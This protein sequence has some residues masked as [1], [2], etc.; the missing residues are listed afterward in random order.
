MERTGGFS[1]H[2]NG[3]VSS[4]V[5]LDQYGRPFPRGT[6][7][8]GSAR[9]GGI[10]LPHAFTL[11]ARYEGADHTYLHAR[12]DEALRK[13]RE[14]AEVM[15]RDAYLM[16]LLQER[17]LAVSGLNWHLEVPDDKDRYQARVRDGMR[18]VVGGIP[19]LRRIIHWLTEAVWYGRYG[20][21]LS[22]K[23]STFMDRPG[24][25]EQP[26]Q[27]QQQ[28][29]QPGGMMPGMPPG[30]PPPPGGGDDDDKRPRGRP[31][32]CL[33]V[34]QCWPVNG[35][36]IGYQHDH[37]PYVLV[38]PDAAT[39]LPHAE[40][41]STTIGGTGLALRGSWRE[42]FL[43]HKHLMEDVD[44]F[45]GEQADAVHGVGIRSKLFWLN[46]LKLEWLANVTDFFD[47]VGLGMTIWKY[48][49][50]NDAA[51]KEALTAA[52]NQSARAHVLVPVWGE[53]GKEALTGVDRLDVP[54]AGSEGLIKLIEYVDR[55]L[56]RYVVGQQGSSRANPSGIGNEAATTFM[57]ETKV[58]ITKHDAAMMAV[59]LTGSAE[60]PGLLST[61]QKWTFP[62]ADFPVRWVFDVERTQNEGTLNSIRTLVDLGL[63]VKADEVRS[64]AGLS[65]PAEGDE[66]VKGP[67]GGPGGAPGGGMPPPGGGGMPGQAPAPGGPEQQQPE[68]QQ[69]QEGGDDDVERGGG[70]LRALQM[71]RGG[72]EGQQPERY[73]WQNRGMVKISPN[74][75]PLYRWYDPNLRQARVQN[76][77]PG[78]GGGNGPRK[79]GKGPGRTPS[80]A[81]DAGPRTLRVVARLLKL[82]FPGGW[83][84]ASGL[85]ALAGAEAGA[86]L[87]PW[88]R[89][90]PDGSAVIELHP[91]GGGGGGESSVWEL[92]LRPG[93]RVEMTPGAGEPS[94]LAL[95]AM[96]VAGVDAL[97]G[98]T[99]LPLD[100]VPAEVRRGNRKR[101]KYRL[102]N[103]REMMELADEFLPRPEPAPDE[104]LGAVLR[105]LRGQGRHGEAD[106]VARAYAR[107]SSSSSRRTESR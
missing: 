26:G 40:L 36:K 16:A 60:E 33:T 25:K 100:G 29:Q 65:K 47:R 32:R 90:D 4:P 27:Q 21:Q 71:A 43:I 30:M 61:I 24:R 81:L 63:E 46:W 98:G 15:R 101:R 23:W 31:R 73:D 54:T 86:M 82:M 49:A 95:K 20:V 106:E 14:D 93:G 104:R 52:Q 80:G 97:A 74:G 70:F 85:P 67:I 11:L 7:P 68:Q 10:A 89:R 9:V 84:K 12:Y 102:K 37:T 66:V 48:P 99:P 5:L 2:T 42:R 51:R 53:A 28:Q 64:A 17:Q 22:W 72:E 96:A 78:Q 55:Q 1:P 6:R 39:R 77:R 50:G 57:Q 83:V 88:P 79:R 59:T 18:R 103:A 45:D 3:S 56:E 35:D 87:T 58:Q 41:L 8:D 69:Q 91:E 105:H 38:A 13:G 75:L 92:A 19:Q 62:E 107:R 94:E 34:A 76:V 44:F